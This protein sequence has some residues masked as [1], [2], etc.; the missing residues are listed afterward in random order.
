MRLLPEFL[1]PDDEAIDL[2]A[3]Y[4]Y[5]TARMAG[6]VGPRGRVYAFEP[7]PATCRVFKRLLASLNL[8]NVEL[9]EKGAGARNDTVVFHVPLQDFGAP[10]AGI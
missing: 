5:Y 1:G 4:A 2:G 10:S 7:I 6:L 3:N 9:I 8:Q